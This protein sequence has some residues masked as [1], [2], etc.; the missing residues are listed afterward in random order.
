MIDKHGCKSR[1]K[2]TLSAAFSTKESLLLERH[3]LPPNSSGLVIRL[4]APSS[5]VATAAF[6]RDL[7]SNEISLLC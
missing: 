6:F 5:S 7:L 4:L 3:G 2:T 1:T